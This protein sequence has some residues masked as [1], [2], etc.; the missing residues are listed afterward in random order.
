MH[1]SKQ[2]EKHEKVR[3]TACFVMKQAVFMV[4]GEG[5]ELF[6]LCK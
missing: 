4:A 1:L 2:P 5:F 3:K 6:S